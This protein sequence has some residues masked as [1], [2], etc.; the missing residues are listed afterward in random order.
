[1]ATLKDPYVRFIHSFHVYRL[2]HVDSAYAAAIHLY[3]CCM[4]AIAAKR[5]GPSIKSAG[6]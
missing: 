1:L 6:V 5:D 4:Y 2:N 3:F